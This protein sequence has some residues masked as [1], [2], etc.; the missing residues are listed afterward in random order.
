[1]TKNFA[2]GKNC[3]WKVKKKL[4]FVQE[5]KLTTKHFDNLLKFGDNSVLF[6]LLNFNLNFHLFVYP[7]A[8]NLTKF[9]PKCKWRHMWF[10]FTTQNRIKNNNF[11][12]HKTNWNL[13]VFGSFHRRVDS[14]IHVLGDQSASKSSL[15]FF[16]RS[17]SFS[18]LV[19]ANPHVKFNSSSPKLL[20]SQRKSPFHF[21]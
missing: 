14:L 1:M 11:H 13:C 21:Q 18:T 3:K 17:I 20:N 8:I 16:K 4:T 2:E 15:T 6:V 9:N 10:S 7:I 19:S 12:N 5:L